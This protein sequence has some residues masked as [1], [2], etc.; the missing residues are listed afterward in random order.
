M[1]AEKKTLFYEWS[2][3]SKLSEIVVYGKE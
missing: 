3:S 2:V 1:M